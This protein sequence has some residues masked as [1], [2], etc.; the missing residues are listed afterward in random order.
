MC[1]VVVEVMRMPCGYCVLCV[2]LLV[3]PQQHHV[4]VLCHHHVD[5]N[6]YQYQHARPLDK[7]R[8]SD[9]TIITTG[10]SR[11]Y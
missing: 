8:V 11:G 9:N 3:N 5:G 7:W 6:L 10:G 1:G 4:V 2:H